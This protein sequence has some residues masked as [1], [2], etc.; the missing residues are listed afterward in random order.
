VEQDLARPIGM[1][2]WRRDLQ[3]KSGDTTRSIHLAYH[4]WF[5]TRDMARLGYLMLRQGKWN[6]RQVI[7]AAWVRES[8]APIVTSD[9]MNPPSVRDSRLSYGYLWW[10]LE[11]PAGSL[12]AGAYSARGA[13]GQYILIAPRLDMV[14]AHKRALRPGDNTSVS[15]AQFMEIAR[16]VAGARCPRGECSITAN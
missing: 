16:Q 13:Y 10:I 14:I 3:Q 11:E 15:W 2:D 4:M 1:E 8:T 12:L 6:D 7:P 5:S 9:R